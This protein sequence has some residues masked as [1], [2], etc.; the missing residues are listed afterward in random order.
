MAKVIHPSCDPMGIIADIINKGLKITMA[1]WILSNKD[2][3][4]LVMFMLTFEHGEDI[5]K[6]FEIETIQG[7]RV[8]IQNVRS[9]FIPQCKH[10]QGY[11]HTQKYCN[12]Q[13]KCVKKMVIHM[14]K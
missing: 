9:K 14:P 12:L 3:Y 11:G 5:K 2:K 10:C 8:K 7:V 6:I 13:P 1:T 4:S